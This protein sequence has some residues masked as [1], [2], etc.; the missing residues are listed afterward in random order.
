MGK[1]GPKPKPIGPRFWAK[2]DKDGAGGCWLWTGTT[3]G[4]G[5]GFFTING[6]MVSA[7]RL[8]YRM[9]HGDIPNEMAL[10]HICHVHNCVNPAHLRPATN[11]ENGYNRGCNGNNSSGF[12]GVSWEPA[13]HKW[14]ATIQAGGKSIIIGRFITAELAHSAYCES[15]KKHHGEFA[16]TGGL[17]EPI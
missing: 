17:P 16:F 5:Y 10:D 12:K 2:V 15:A 14:R 9:A 7:H 8:A 1:R 11:T 13:R 6:R 4:K 3:R